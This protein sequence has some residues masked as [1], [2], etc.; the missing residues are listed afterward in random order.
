MERSV[1]VHTSSHE[2]C[3]HVILVHGTYGHGVLRSL[4]WNLLPSNWR[5]RDCNWPICKMLKDRGVKVHSFSW[6][7]LNN[8]RSRIEAGRELADYIA[9]LGTNES[10][11]MFIS[12]VGH[13]HGG[14]VALY[15][16]KHPDTERVDSIV[17]LATPFLH[18]SAQELDFIVLRF[19]PLVLSIPTCLIVGLVVL[20]LLRDLVAFL[21]IVLP[22]QVIPI[23]IVG[24]GAVGYIFAI[25]MWRAAHR[26]LWRVRAYL[27]R[28]PEVCESY[29]PATPT[30]QR[31]LILR[32]IGDEATA[33]LLA[34]RFVEW[35]LTCIWWI[36]S[37]PVRLA[38]RA[39]KAID[40]FRAK[41]LYQKR[42]TTP[43][44]ERSAERAREAKNKWTW[45][46]VN[47][48][49]V[50][51]CFI[52]VPR[53][54]KDP[55]IKHFFDVFSILVETIVWRLLDLV[56]L[57]WLLLLAQFCLVLIAV[58]LN[59]CRFGGM[60]DL[61]PTFFLQVNAE[62]IPRGSWELE[63]FPAKGF[64]PHSEIHQDPLVA[65][66]AA[67]WLLANDMHNPA[68]A[69]AEPGCSAGSA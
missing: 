2:P 16:L 63:L 58:A 44:E 39:K 66:R 35:L 41:F 6:S 15:A 47:T 11:P 42:H 56:W 10:Q 14:N 12:I 38:D 1:K 37:S 30:R 13:S 69:E 3:R 62:P 55:N 31:V 43:C 51:A 9:R 65:N 7:G 49:I 24:V 4:F 21:Q 26:M 46:I 67:M 53:I 57:V 25:L 64:R 28:L 45:R 50:V 34:G 5:L 20:F 48:A 22:S 61:L 8:H 23:L 17:C 52:L 40:K 27:K 33:Y 60:K 68:H 29:Q 54:S 36:L 32:K 19:L 18:V 59:F